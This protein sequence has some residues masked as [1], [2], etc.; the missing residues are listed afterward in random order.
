MPVWTPR[1]LIA[2][3]NRF[4]EVMGQVILLVLYFALLG[5]IALTLRLFA[6]PLRIRRPR[7]S[8]FTRWQRSNETLSAARRQ[9]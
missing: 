9:G 6:D 4:G 7:G 5:P 2:F 8:A 1:H 3:L